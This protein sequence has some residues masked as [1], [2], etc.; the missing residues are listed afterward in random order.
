MLPARATP[1]CAALL[2][3]AAACGGCG[4][5]GGPGDAKGRAS[6]TPKFAPDPEARS[7]PST[8]TTPGDGPGG[9]T[10]STTSSG[11]DARTTTTTAATAV[12]VT[13]ASIADKLGDRTP[14]V[15]PPPPW[16]DLAGAVLTR[17]A[18]G[19]ELRVRLGG[20]SAPSSTDADHTMNVASF[21]DVDGD[22]TID[23]EV[24]ANL[25][26]SGWG[27]SYFDRP[28][29][30][31]LFQDKSGVAVSVEGDALVL[32][33]PFSHLGFAERFRWSVAS[34][35]GRY[36]VLGTTA[37]ARDDAPDNDAAARFPG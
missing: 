29:S 2:C 31:A 36:E 33:F 26:S 7:T 13:T 1:L 14:S 35:W 18:E 23:F 27:T 11:R 4:G 19:Y 28:G 3:V 5:K 17:R 6:L 9:S 21:Y 12:A 20:G 30:R 32:R 37:T 15:D 10:S 34:E 22:G 25:A 16:S 8:T 24:W